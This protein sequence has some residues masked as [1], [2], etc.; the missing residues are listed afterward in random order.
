MTKIKIDRT[1]NKDLRNKAL[2][3]NGLSK[4]LKL[5]ILLDAIAV[6]CTIINV[7]Q[8]LQLLWRQ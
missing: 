8:V 1:A 2:R 7:G 4:E 6:I 5:M 3:Q